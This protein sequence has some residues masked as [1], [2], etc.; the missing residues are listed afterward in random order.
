MSFM[1]FM[2]F[3]LLMLLMVSTEAS[4]QVECQEVTVENMCNTVVGSSLNGI[5]TKVEQCLIG[6]EG[7][8]KSVYYS[9]DTLFKIFW[10]DSQNDWDLGQRCDNDA[11]KQNNQGVNF[12]Y[13][14]IYIYAA[15]PPLTPPPPLPPPV[16]NR[17]ALVLTSLPMA[18]V[19]STKTSLSFLLPLL[20]RGHAGTTSTK[21]SARLPPSLL[22]RARLEVT[23]L[24]APKVNFL[25]ADSNPASRAPRTYLTPYHLA[26]RPHRAASL[27]LKTWSPSHRMA[28]KF[29][30]IR[31][32]RIRGI[33]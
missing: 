20:T 19:L 32:K 15:P 12:I 8:S 25:P 3:M 30:R 1:S 11:K 14:Y 27:T 23:R 5:Y 16:A 31:Q 18:T 13:I 10:P 6:E 29:F 4:S 33:F 28:T 17:K 26:L 7:S 9:K 24:S 22:L 2:S 21:N